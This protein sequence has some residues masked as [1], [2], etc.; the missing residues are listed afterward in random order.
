[1]K[2]HPF[3]QAALAEIHARPFEVFETPRIVFQQ[4]FMSAKTGGR[5]FQA[6]SNWCEKQG[7]EGPSNTA[8]HHVVLLKNDKRLVWER[9]QEFITL[10][11]DCPPGKDAARK[12]ALF[13][14]EN[15][16]EIIAPGA[17][18]ICLVQ[19]EL[20]KQ[21]QREMR[22]FNGFDSENTC[23]SSIK[24][25]KVLIATDFK[26]QENGATRF[27]VSNKGIDGVSMGGVV[28]R[29]LEI[30]TYRVLALIGFV[31]AKQIIPAVKEVEDRLVDL[32]SEMGETGDLDTSRSLLKTITRLASQLEAV[33]VS[34]QYRMSA[35]KAY[36]N[37]VNFRLGILNSQPYQD[38]MS[39]EEFLGR[40]MAPA[41]RTC[42][43]IEERI[44]IASK[45]LS[46]SANLLRTKVDIHVEAQNHDLLDSMD[47]RAKQQF[48]LQQTVEGLSIAAVSY[49]IVGLIGYL[50]KGSMAI[51]GI[52]SGVVTALSVPLVLMLVWGL[53]R[54]IRKKHEG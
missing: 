10:T 6:F 39:I 22:S 16:A 40:R 38:R 19:L 45:K 20:I 4:A 34:S 23:V 46:R 2:D 18:L 1:M 37:L 24:D 17:E 44:A 49:Y 42:N 8:R 36:Y 15:E 29:L 54:R 11:W 33:S 12:L 50:A 32:T 31:E 27:V 9:H 35:T 51:T 30:E 25:G 7:V 28:R 52:S 13:A 53:V 48:R 43:G 5:N 21:G 47:R 26:I 14:G 3:R 41:M